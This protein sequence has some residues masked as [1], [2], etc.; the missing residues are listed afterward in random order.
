MLRCHANEALNNIVGIVVVAKEIL[1]AEKHLNRCLEVLLE[2]VEA[3]PRI[4]VEEA[5]AGIVRCAAPCLD[6]L[7][8]DAVEIFELRHHV[9]EAHARCTKRLMTITKD[10]LHNFNRIFSH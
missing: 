7:V 2:G 8:A 3:L 10:S 1:A 6:C 5:E 9:L 4:F